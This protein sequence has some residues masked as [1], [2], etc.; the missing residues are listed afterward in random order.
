MIYAEW[1]G[2]N[3]EI[4]RQKMIKFCRCFTVYKKL[5]KIFQLISEKPK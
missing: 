2:I 4:T 1:A 5:E 3:V